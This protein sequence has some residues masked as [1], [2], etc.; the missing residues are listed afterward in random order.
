MSGAQ[1]PADDDLALQAT[2][3]SDEALGPPGVDRATLSV[4]PG[5]V[6]VAAPDLPR[7]DRARYQVAGEL[8]RGGLG[9]ILRARD[10]HLDRNVALK[11]MLSVGT[12][13]ERRFV[14]EALITARLEHPA[15]VP[16]H[17]AGRGDDGAPF[18][19]MKLVGGRP[20]AEVAAAARTT[21]QRLALVPT[22]LSVADA[23]AYAHSEG[24]IH[25]DLKPH[26]VLVGDYGETVVIDWGLAKDL[27]ATDDLDAATAALG[28]ARTLSPEDAP[29]AAAAGVTPRSH[30]ASDTVGGAVLGTPA[31]M[32]P[33]QAA[34]DP[35]DERADVYA[36]GAMLYEVLAGVGPHHGKTIEDVLLNVV[37]GKIRP[38]GERVPELPRDLVAIVGKAMA[39]APAARYRTARE[40]ADDLRRYV[41]G[42]LVVVYRYGWRE[43]AWRW[44]RR[45]RAPV[46]VAAVAA[47]VLAVVATVAVQRVV[48]ERDDARLARR[49]AEARQDDARA[50]ARRERA[51]AGRAADRAGPGRAARLIPRAR[52]ALLAQ[53]P[54]QA[55]AWAAARVVAAEARSVGVGD[56][57]VG[58]LHPTVAVAVSSDG[59]RVASADSR[60]IRVWD[61]AARTAR[62]ITLPP[63][64]GA[65]GECQYSGWRLALSSDGRTLA[66][67]AG[68][69]YVWDVDDLAAAART[70]P[71]EA[72]W[73][74]DDGATWLGSARGLARIAPAGGEAPPWSCPARPGAGRS[75]NSGEAAVAIDADA[76]RIWARGQLRV[77]RMPVR[78]D[79]V[80]LS[81]SGRSAGVGGGG[82]RR[83]RLEPAARSG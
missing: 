43:R 80:A 40:L 4:A 71:G 32:A 14:R 79:A 42:Q 76:L 52:M 82:A 38:L 70:H 81:A 53:L 1:P 58:H 75:R 47:V 50:A 9:R 10:L 24:V 17:D 6:G 21:Q 48:A 18:Y 39:H 78:V 67:V 33:E 27:R 72:V 73:L 51:R 62:V 69:V 55:D 61:L 63:P 26:N 22:V 15:I 59:R 65:Q 36:L 12:E 23:L 41:T 11:E 2:A 7:V 37:G 46:A 68:L 57:L 28:A 49:I 74:T 8:A 60:D 54:A 64:C 13:A 3:I 5:E 25:R 16:V 83:G 44:L 66:A 29:P 77:Q 30:H 45:N 56:V 35:V 31:Y 34:G 20:L 19:A